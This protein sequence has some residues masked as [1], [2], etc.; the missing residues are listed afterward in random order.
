[1]ILKNIMGYLYK[2]NDCHFES[3]LVDEKSLGI[4]RFLCR[5]L[6]NGLLRNDNNRTHKVRAINFGENDDNK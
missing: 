5:P 1:M 4:K 2:S 6:T 3:T